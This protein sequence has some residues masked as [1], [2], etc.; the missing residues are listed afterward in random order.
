MSSSPS[1]MLRV[2]ARTDPGKV[3]EENQDRISRFRTP[4]GE[5][6]LV[7]DGMGGH[8]G[9]SLAAQLVVEGLERELR[10]ADPGAPPVEVLRVAAARVNAEIQA[11]AAAGGERTAKMGATVVLALLRDRRLTVAHAG[12]SRAYLYRGSILTRLTRDHTVVQRMIDHNMLTEE[13]AQDHPD[14]SV[15]NRAFG[16]AEFE[17]E[18]AQPLELAAG[19]S[20]LLCS[21]GLCGYVDEPAIAEAIGRGDGAQATTDRLIELALAAGGEDNVSVQFLSVHGGETAASGAAV[22]AARLGRRDALP[23]MPSDRRRVM[24]VLSL[25]LLVAVSVLAGFLV[26]KRLD[27][28]RSSAEPPAA[29][30]A[31]KVIE[32]GRPGREID[33]P[34]QPVRPSEPEADGVDPPATTAP[35]IPRLEPPAGE[36]RAG[37]SVRRGGLAFGGYQLYF[38][39]V[40]PDRNPELEGSQLQPRHVYHPP[41]LQP[42]AREVA[43]RLGF[44]EKRVEAVSLTPDTRALVINLPLRAPAKRRS[45][46]DAQIYYAEG[47]KDIAIE[48][49]KD[50]DVSRSPRSMSSFPG[51]IAESWLVVVPAAEDA[52]A[53]EPHEDDDGQED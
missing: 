8:Q 36:P 11:R 41:A 52:P 3:R 25:A 12:D 40:R 16:R 13:E 1:F 32:P 18:V 6:F 7:V 28:S 5:A 23:A 46:E 26:A 21:D 42:E 44:Q 22:P 9:G 14:A 24:Y 4:L 35:E 49:A 43:R 27:P 48:L 30:E 31:P 50:L 53:T 47:L 17:I 37:F 29:D 38:E 2:G 20:V 39:Y 34:D 51:E 45:W 33:R 19:D 15:V 10:S